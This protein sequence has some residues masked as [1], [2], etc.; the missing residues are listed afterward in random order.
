MRTSWPFWC[1]LTILAAALMSVA[2]A[3]PPVSLAQANAQ[4]DAPAENPEEPGPAPPPPGVPPLLVGQSSSLA[5]QTGRLLTEGTQRAYLT[6]AEERR[7][8][9]LTT[10]LV[11]DSQTG[12]LVAA[13]LLAVPARQL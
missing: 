4:P 8:L 9:S 2:L 13:P 1:C 6:D 3:L 7:L 10:A 12:P 11:T 5:S